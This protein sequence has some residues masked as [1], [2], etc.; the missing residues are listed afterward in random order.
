MCQHQRIWPVILTI[1]VCLCCPKQS[2]AQEEE[3]YSYELEEFVNDPYDII[4]YSE[5][6][7]KEIVVSQVKSLVDR[8]ELFTLEEQNDY[9]FDVALPIDCDPEI[10]EYCV[11]MGD[12]C[13]SYGGG[14]T[15]YINKPTICDPGLINWI[16]IKAGTSAHAGSPANMWLCLGK[17]YRTYTGPAP[18]YARP[19]SKRYTGS[20]PSGMDAACINLGAAPSVPNAEVYYHFCNGPTWDSFFSWLEPDDWDDI[21]FWFGS[22]NGLQVAE[23]EIVLGNQQIYLETG[24][25]TWLDLYYGRQLFM[26]WRVAEYKHDLLTAV[27]GKDYLNPILEVAAQDLGQSGSRKYRIGDGAWCSDFAVYAIQQ[28]ARLSIACSGIPRPLV[29]GD[30]GVQDMFTWLDGCGRMIPHWEL[31]ANPGLMK[32][33]YYLSINNRGHS[34]IFVDWVGAP[35]GMMWIIDG[36]GMTNSVRLRQKYWGAVNAAQPGMANYD[37]AGNTY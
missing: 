29:T 18:D 5:D 37:F 21:R 3:Q 9:Y 1:S 10:D 35:G 27:V 7:L 8:V 36:N 6:N 20:P 17:H 14:P 34:V 19:E 24:I 33:G 26:D 23:I 13:G 32:P 12:G 28:G 2:T 25:N 16:R 11:E 4:P 31:D 15:F 22:T 30:I